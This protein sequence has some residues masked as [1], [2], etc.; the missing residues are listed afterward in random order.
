MI[1]KKFKISG[2][3]GQGGS[4]KVFLVTDEHDNKFAMKVVANSKHFSNNAAMRVLAHEVSILQQASD[5]PNII[6]P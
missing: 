5:H 1:A 2:V 3:L 6:Q 4:A